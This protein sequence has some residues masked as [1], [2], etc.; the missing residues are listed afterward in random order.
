[1]SIQSLIRRAGHHVDVEA[2]SVTRDTTGAR[3]TGHNTQ[4]D[5]VACWVQPA[6][7][8]VIEAYAQRQ[9][10]ATHVVYFPENPGIAGDGYRLKWGTRYLTVLSSGEDMAGLGKGWRVVCEEAV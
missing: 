6:G 10:R 3:A 8:T 4:S 1:M 9:L 7:S 2:P 5:E